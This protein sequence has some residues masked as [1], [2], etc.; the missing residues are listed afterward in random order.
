M[1]SADAS[2]GGHAGK[3]KWSPRRTGLTFGAGVLAVGVLVSGSLWWAAAVAHRDVADRALADLASTAHV[4]VMEEDAAWAQAVG[5]LRGV[6]G[7][8]SVEAAVTSG[9]TRLAESVAQVLYGSDRLAGVSIFDAS[10]RLL[11]ASGAADL[12]APSATDTGVVIGPVTVEGQQVRRRLV[13]PITGPDRRTIGQVVAE[14]DVTKLLP[15]GPSG[16]FGRT[17][18]S[19]L[20][21]GAGVVVG[22]SEGGYGLTLKARANLEMVAAGKPATATVYSPYYNRWQVESYQP[23]PDQGLGVLTVQAESEVLAGANSL[24]ARLHDGAALALGLG[25]LGGAAVGGGLYRRRRRITALVEARLAA[26]SRMRVAWQ[27]APLGM[28]IVGLD[29]VWQAL[30]PAACAMFGLAEEELVG[31]DYLDFTHPDDRHLGPAELA[32]IGAGSLEVFRL[33]K[34]FLRADGRTWWGAVTFSGVPGPDGRPEYAIVEIEDVTAARVA[35]E[36]LAAS[37]ARYRST[38]DSLEEGVISFQV[39]D[40]QPVAVMANPAAAR[41]LGRDPVGASA[42]ELHT[43]LVQVRGA[44][45]VEIRPDDLPVSRAARTSQPVRREEI[46][47]IFDD[48]RRTWLSAGAQ[49]VAGD[50]G[51]VVAVTASFRDVTAAHAAE[52][53]VESAH[54]RSAALI[55]HGSDLITVSDRQGRIT[56]ASPAC[57]RLL[58][59]HP[60]ELVGRSVLDWVHPDDRERVTEVHEELLARPGGSSEYE[61][62]LVHRD[63]TWRHMEVIRTNHLDDPAIAGIVATK[64][65]VTERVDAAEKLLRQATHDALTGLPNRALL[66]DRLEAALARTGRGGSRCAVLFLDLD[67]FKTINDSLGHAAGDRLLQ[68]VGE[69][70]GSVIR[71]QDTVARLGGD[72]F[73]V[74]A[75]DIDTAPLAVELAERVRAAVSRSADLGKRTVTITCSVGIALSDHHGAD[76][77][78]QQADTALYRAKGRGRN[79]W[80]MY[81]QAM[82]TV[83]RRRLDVEME[84]RHAIDEDRIVVAYQPVVRLDDG[85][86][87]GAEALVRLRA[88]DGRMMLP[89]EFIEAA[90]DSGL[91]VPLGASVLRQACAQEAAW[92]RGSGPFRDRPG[93]VA[94][95]LSARQLADSHLADEV[96]EALSAN[97]LRPDQLCLELT[98]SVLIDAGSST[99]RIIESLAAMGI[100][101]AIDDF[102]TG[103]SSL[104]Y[105]RRFPIDTIKIDRSFVAGLGRDEGDTEVV[106]AVVSLGK[107]LDLTLVAEGIETEDQARILT[108]MG[109]DYG[110]GWLFGKPVSPELVGLAR[111]V[112]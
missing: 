103:W 57:E 36:R 34:R 56:F 40:G 72:E 112:G 2:A 17:G 83:A 91:I 60:D 89:D 85:S 71:P 8:T 23:A 84:L 46:E 93:S 63:G 22:G 42:D 105:L 88:V 61:C 109:C 4:T 43:G 76:A 96:V 92:T 35:Q 30:N 48:G 44:D 15:F 108:D 1:S 50:D 53:A 68:L 78:L 79:R 10:G 81:D 7:S 26:E 110:Q 51:G 70:L 19:S 28:V 37:E 107:A 49:V 12:S 73:V 33:E 94:V 20:V 99:R 98:E 111:V 11:A 14:V 90:E 18:S 32:R 31:R 95:N 6:A 59:W 62:R 3:W 64:R 39:F 65:D 82:R 101:L 80:E 52:E 69:R 16:R 24:A 29:G 67:Q 9:D 38:L 27:S 75:E 47:L 13:Y 45:G 74:L 77:L 21:D 97:G 66:L 5:S 86:L 106:K 25:L 54:A 104:A 100:R 102:G 87:V 41:V 55:E 58:G